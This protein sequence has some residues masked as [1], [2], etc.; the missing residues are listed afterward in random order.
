VR[1]DS[2]TNVRAQHV[3]AASQRI[4]LIVVVQERNE[5]NDNCKYYN[6]SSLR[7]GGRWEGQMM[8][9]E[10]HD[11]A[12]DPCIF[13]RALIQYVFIYGSIRS[14]NTIK[15]FLILLS[16]CEWAVTYF[17]QDKKKPV[18]TINNNGTIRFTST[19]AYESYNISPSAFYKAIRDLKDR[20]LIRVAHKGGGS[21]NRYEILTPPLLK[22]ITSR[23][24]R[25]KQRENER[26]VVKSVHDLMT[27]M[28]K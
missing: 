5:Y 22:P 26:D 1:C 15:V 16:K 3:S 9:S 8:V 14:I 25:A 12:L 2:E 11:V 21:G 7:N 19:D 23:L 17:D 4:R 10:P 20:L 27:Y 28:T 18:A 24:R 6:A 13:D